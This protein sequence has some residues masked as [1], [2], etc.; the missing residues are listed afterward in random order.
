VNGQLTPLP[1][2]LRPLAAELEA[3]H[4]ELHRL[5]DEGEAGR[6]AVVKGGQV[7]STWDT[8]RDAIQYGYEKFGLEPFLAQP[9][10]ARYEQELAKYFGPTPVRE[11]A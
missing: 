7:V 11:S 3:F 8:Y 9:I 1:A 5:L 4:R 2:E 10:D 6:Y